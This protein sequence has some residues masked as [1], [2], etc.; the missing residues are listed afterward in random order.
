M[1]APS[2]ALSRVP[3]YVRLVRRDQV[4]DRLRHSL[5]FGVLGVTKPAAV[6]IGSDLYRSPAVEE[7]LD[8][9]GID[10]SDRLM[11][12]LAIGC[13]RVIAG[14]VIDGDGQ[15]GTW[16]AADITRWLRRHFVADDAEQIVKALSL[17]VTPG[18]VVQDC[19]V[20]GDDDVVLA[21]DYRSTEQS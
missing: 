10:L 15:C 5:E 9:G 8:R 19:V 12:A 6:I 1:Q 16:T 14:Y 3:F 17:L 21:D 4:E 2:N 20:V 18:M 11:D 13:F 7:R